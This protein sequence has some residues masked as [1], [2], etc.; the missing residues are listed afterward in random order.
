[1]PRPSISIVTPS[2]NQGHFLETTIRSVLLQRYPA[3]EYLV[4][5]GGS[6]DGSREIIERYSDRLAFWR[7]ERDGGHAAA[8][9][10]GFE[11]ATGDVLGFLNSDDVLLPGALDAV[12]EFFARNP[13]VSA[14]YGH[15]LLIDSGGFVHGVWLL[16]PHSDYLMLRWDLI[17]QETCFWRRSLFEAAGNVDPRR[18][19]ALDYDLFARYMRAGRFARMDRFLGAFRVHPASKTT[20]D[21]AT[22]GRA[23]IAAIRAA[24]G[25]RVSAAEETVGSVFSAYVQWRSRRYVAGRARARPGAPAHAGYHVDA[26]WGG[27]LAETAGPASPRAQAE[28]APGPSI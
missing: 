25:L 13:A 20:M 11:R 24:Q 4:L 10:E 8:V 1:M 7:A 26:L 18:K 23:E 3:L 2:F 28:P 16:P 27:L 9:A 6:T 15:R 17:P 5:D 19:F 22:I 12:A 14:V 21:H